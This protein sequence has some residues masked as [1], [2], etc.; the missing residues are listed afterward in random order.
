VNGTLIPLDG[1]SEPLQRAVEHLLEH[2][3]LLETIGDPADSIIMDYQ[4]QAVALQAR[5]ARVVAEH[6]AQRMPG[7]ASGG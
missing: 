3:E 2:P 1:R 4:T 6:R 7:E 5:L